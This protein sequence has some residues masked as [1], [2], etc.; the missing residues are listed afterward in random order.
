MI[1]RKFLQ[2]SE[3]AGARERARAANA[4]ARA[5]ALS[6]LSTEETRAAEAAMA[7]LLDD[8]SPMVRQAMAEALATSSRAPRSVIY[9]L[10][11]D[12]LD[13]AG[14]V[15]CCSP[16][17]KDQ[18]LVDL[19][20]DGRPGIQRAI[21]MRHEVSPAVCAALAEVAG[22]VPVCELLDNF[23]ARVAK[24]TIRRITER[25]GNEP[26]MRARLLERSDLPCDV[27]HTLIMKVGEAL[28]GSKFVAGVVGRGRVQR[29]TQDAC[30]TATLHLAGNIGGDEIP[31]LVEHLRV[32]GTLTPAFLMHALCV[33]NIDF[34]AAAIGSVA[35]VS[36]NRV[37]GIL[38]DGR[39]NAIQALYT[40]G[41]I[42]SAV[43]EVFVTATL[44]WRDATRA[45]TRPNAMRI[46]ESLIDHYAY[47]ADDSPIAELLG[48]VE[49]MNLDFRRQAARDYAV[50][51]T[52]E[53]A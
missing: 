21:A 11:R 15:V 45:Q 12:Q 37:R 43:G 9:G 7:L 14:I 1:V 49:R 35:G 19:A 6:E 51:M 48:L 42:E 16:L 53:A 39:R 5:Y 31:A 22:L 10:A 40:S 36:D 52:Y 2:W 20:A 47:L 32:A 44:L 50:S 38:V 27:R 13:V 28:A 18:D 24:V 46:T 33:G 3:T 8:P 41:G 17:L 23:S 29:I 34:F 25:F 4:L 30:H 26:D